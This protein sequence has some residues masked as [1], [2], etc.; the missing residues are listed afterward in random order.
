MIKIHQRLGESSSNNQPVQPTRKH[1]KP[2]RE[3]KRTE[4]KR[5]IG[6]RKIRRKP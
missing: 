3:K 5:K 4:E 2:P 1:I 6:R